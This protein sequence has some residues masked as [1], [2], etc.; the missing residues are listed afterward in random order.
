M[1]SVRNLRNITDRKSD[2]NVTIENLEHLMTEL[3]YKGHYYIEYSDSNV[4][5]IQRLIRYFERADFEVERLSSMKIRV[6]WR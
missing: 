2:F 3:A 4:H 5:I 6:Y 1:I